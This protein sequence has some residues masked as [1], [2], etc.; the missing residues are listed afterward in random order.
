LK[1]DPMP[2]RRAKQ[3]ENQQTMTE[4][5]Q[6]APTLNN[7]LLAVK[8]CAPPTSSCDDSGLNDSRGLGIPL[9]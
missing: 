6:H 3:R 1:H 7:Q 9:A 4:S 2:A 5:F 8:K